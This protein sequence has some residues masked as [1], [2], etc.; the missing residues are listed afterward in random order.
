MSPRPASRAVALAL[1][2]ALLASSGAQAVVIFDNITGATFTTGGYRV[3]EYPAAAGETAP[4]D[5]RVATRFTLEGNQQ[6]QLN[7]VAM[8]VAADVALGGAVRAR[9]WLAEVAEGSGPLTTYELG[10]VSTTATGPVTVAVEGLASM[11][12]ALQGGNSYWLVVGSVPGDP[13]ETRLRW[14]RSSLG[15]LGTTFSD[16]LETPE[17]Y[18]IAEGRTPGMRVNATL[19][20]APGALAVLAMGAMAR[21]RRR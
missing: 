21:R 2:V 19:I 3:G 7:A 6:W 5:Y 4:H 10:T 11:N 8:R 15:T 14:L 9:V 12:I 20:P 18:A 13:D 1:P 16:D 17:G